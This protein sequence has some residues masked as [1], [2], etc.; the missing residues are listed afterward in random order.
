MSRFRVLLVDDEEGFLAPLV[1]RLSKRKLDVSWATGGREA[2]A[3]M[4]DSP[5]DVV[6]LDVKMP[7][8]DGITT[9]AQMKKLDPSVEVI[10]LTGHASLEAAMEG[11]RLGAFDYLMK[12]ADFDELFYKL[13]D[14]FKRKVCQEKTSECSIAGN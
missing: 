2:L 5:V 6:V 9:L 3:K 4:R 1:K 7:D 14:A 8:L 12:P 10:M 13:E 11:M